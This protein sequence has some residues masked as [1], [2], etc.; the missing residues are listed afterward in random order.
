M[1]KF[2]SIMRNITLWTYDHNKMLIVFNWSP[3]LSIYIF[4]LIKTAPKTCSAK[5]K[6]ES[7]SWKILTRFSINS[8][9]ILREFSRLHSTTMLFDSCSPE[10][11]GRTNHGE[12]KRK[13]D[14]KNWSE[15]ERSHATQH[16]AL[17]LL[18]IIIVISASF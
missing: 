17:S 9:L 6:E 11:G 13:E 8:K 4:Y 7:S 5:N 12:R 2:N 15:E 18:L 10:A 14:G 3:M 16:F 1:S